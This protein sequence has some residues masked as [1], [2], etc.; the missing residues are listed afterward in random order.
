[1]ISNIDFNIDRLFQQEGL[2][3]DQIKYFLF[4]KGY[5]IFILKEN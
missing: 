1:M 3:I 5:D 2:S 4:D